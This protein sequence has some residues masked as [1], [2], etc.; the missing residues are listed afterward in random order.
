MGGD[1]LTKGIIIGV[2]AI[3]VTMVAMYLTVVLPGSAGTAAIEAESPGMENLKTDHLAVAIFDGGKVSGYFTARFLGKRSKETDKYRIETM[4]L[5]ALHRAIYAGGI[6][7]AKAPLS[8]D[9]AVLAADVEK[10]V[11]ERARRRLVDDI[12]LDDVAFLAHK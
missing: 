11:N 2:W 4:L 5:D 12:E 8:A 1:T 6:V 7:D 3:I 10:Q 9:F